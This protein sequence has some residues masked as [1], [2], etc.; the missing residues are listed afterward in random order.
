MNFEHIRFEITDGIARLTLNRPENLNAISIR[1]VEEMDHALDIL[2]QADSDARCLLLTGEGRGFSSGADLSAG[3]IPVSDGRPF[4]AGLVLERHYNPLIER[5]ATLSVPFISAVNGVAAGA[6]MSFALAADIVLAGRSAYFLQAFVNIGLVPDAG[7][8]Y[9]L[10][11]L[12]GNARARALMMLGEK[13]PAEKA[14]EWGLIYKVVDDEALSEEADALAKK[15]AEGPTRAL[16]MIREL[17]TASTDTDL[18]T[19]LRMERVAQR[20][21][22]GTSDFVEG[23]SAFLQKR[24]AKFKGK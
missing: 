20:K 24:K 10:S 4:D 14:E 22:S 12:V 19:Q 3:S 17:A 2:E 1:M 11:R 13:L 16:G 9:F 7:S 15:L 23:V 5:L 6:G 8:T 21:A 18:S